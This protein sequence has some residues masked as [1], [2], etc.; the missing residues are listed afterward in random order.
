MSDTSKSPAKPALADEGEVFLKLNL[1]NLSPDVRRDLE[2]HARLARTTPV[3]HIAHLLNLKL[4][5][6]GITL[7]AA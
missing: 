3:N 1:D 2:A 4:A 6:A 7:E 5:P